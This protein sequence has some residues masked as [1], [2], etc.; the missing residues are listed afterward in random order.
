L[1]SA[2]AN[3]IP[4]QHRSRSLDSPSN[5]TVF[6]R[7]HYAIRAKLVQ[8][9]QPGAE[10]RNLLAAASLNGLRKNFYELLNAEEPVPID[11]IVERSGLHS[12]DVLA[13]LFDLEMK[14]IIRQ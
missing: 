4:R 8:A 3:R 9:E 7:H 1:K 14:G 6:Y 12:S 13:T 10:Q 5:L 11:D 2:S